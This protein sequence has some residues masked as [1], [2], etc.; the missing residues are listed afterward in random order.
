MEMTIGS[1]CRAGACWTQFIS[2][3]LIATVTIRMFKIALQPS[4]WYGLSQCAC[5]FPTLLQ[6]VL[7]L[8][9]L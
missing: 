8:D 4:V 9:D 3:L 1:C 2:H 6:L 7:P 5:L